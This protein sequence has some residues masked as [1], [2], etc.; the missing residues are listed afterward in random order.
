MIKR[1]DIVLVSDEDESAA[2]HAADS[3]HNADHCDTV[4]LRVESRIVG[5]TAHVDGR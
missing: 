2:R 1:T 5:A 3:T 4:R